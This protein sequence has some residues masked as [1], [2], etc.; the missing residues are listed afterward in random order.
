[1]KEIIYLIVGIMIFV[2]WIWTL[3]GSIV[4]SYYDNMR[5]DKSHYAHL[6]FFLVGP[7]GFMKWCRHYFVCKNCF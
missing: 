7:F 4:L 3:T 5:C 6:K 2:V 1:M